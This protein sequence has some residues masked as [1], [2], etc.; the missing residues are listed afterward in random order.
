MTSR[1]QLCAVIGAAV[2]GYAAFGASPAA[3]E[4]TKPARE[5]P[6]LTTENATPVI[7]KWVQGANGWVCFELK[8]PH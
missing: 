1:V 3:A 5:E 8:K 7:C 4:E 6:K 2:L